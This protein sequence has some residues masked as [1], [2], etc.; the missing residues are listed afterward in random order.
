MDRMPNRLDLDNVSLTHPIY[1]VHFSQHLGVG[2]TK[3]LIEV[4]YNNSSP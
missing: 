2:N 3:A 4:G 1:I